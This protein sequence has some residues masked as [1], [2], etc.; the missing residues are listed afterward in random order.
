MYDRESYCSI[1][2]LKFEECINTKKSL[3]SESSFSYSYGMSS[4][5]MQLSLSHFGTF[6]GDLLVMV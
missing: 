3:L 5:V 6:P 4:D 1:P 2:T